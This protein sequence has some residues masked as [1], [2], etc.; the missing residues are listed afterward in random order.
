MALGLTQPL[1]KMSTTNLPGSKGWPAHKAHN[2]TAICEPTVLQTCGNLNISQLYGPP[3]PVTGLALPL[4]LPQCS[5]SLSSIND[6]LETTF[7]HK[8]VLKLIPACHFNSQVVETVENR[9]YSI[10]K[11]LIN[12]MYLSAQMYEAV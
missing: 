1:T 6:Q 4:S 8:Y 7:S 11:L 9:N 3:W 12:V 5:P 2:L 10:L